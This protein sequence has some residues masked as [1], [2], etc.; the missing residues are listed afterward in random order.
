M[1]S[2]ERPDDPA[3]V[4]AYNDWYQCSLFR[5]TDPTK[6]PDYM[7]F[8]PATE[9]LIVCTQT[10]SICGPASLAEPRIEVMVGTPLAEFDPKLQAAQ[11][12]KVATIHLKAEGGSDFPGVKVDLSRRAFIHR[13]ILLTAA[14]AKFPI[15][16]LTLA[17]FQGWIARYY[18]RIAM[19]SALVGRIRIPNRTGLQRRVQAILNEYLPMDNGPGRYQVHT[20]VSRFYVGWSPDTELSGQDP[21]TLK[22]LIV[23]TTERT[24]EYLEVRVEE[25]QSG[26]RSKPLVNFIAMAAPEVRVG[27]NVTD[28]DKHGMKRFSEWDELSSPS[29]MLGVLRS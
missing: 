9:W 26:M 24:K 28:A 15:S 7:A 16:Y 6:L 29:E 20:E 12:K 8:D 2:A 10:C 13:E 4:A 14:R 21:Y 3:S 22:L 1:D 18:T 25:L 27:D 17:A 11:G 5:P 19:P 23:C